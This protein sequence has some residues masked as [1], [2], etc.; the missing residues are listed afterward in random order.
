[1][2]PFA[3]SGT[4]ARPEKGGL[5]KPVWLGMRKR[6]PWSACCVSYAVQCPAQHLVV[7]CT[8]CDA[9]KRSFGNSE[10]RPRPQESP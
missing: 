9:L 3:R 7:W 1:M 10:S 4:L 6:E 5:D 8:A 2:L